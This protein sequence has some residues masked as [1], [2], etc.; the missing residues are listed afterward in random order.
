[1]TREVA[2][3]M[4][5]AMRYPAKRTFDGMRPTQKVLDILKKEGPM[6]RDKLWDKCKGSGTMHSNLMRAHQ[7]R[8]AEQNLS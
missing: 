2:R 1:M 6:D 8:H 3:S 5:V 4:R 7:R